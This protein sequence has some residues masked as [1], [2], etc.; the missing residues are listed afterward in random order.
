[1]KDYLAHYGS[2]VD[3]AWPN[4][5]A[6]NASGAGATDGTPYTADFIDDL[7]G[8]RQD[9]L[10]AV[11]MIPDGITE[12]AG[13]SQFLEAFRRGAGLPPGMVVEGFFSPARQALLRLLPLEGQLVPVDTYDQLVD[14]V[15]Q[16]A[17]NNPTVPAFYRCNLDGGRNVAGDF[18]YLPDVRGI[19]LRAAGQSSIYRAANDTPYDGFSAGSFIGDAARK[20]HAYLGWVGN[21]SNIRAPFEQRGSEI[22][23][24]RG[25]D[26][27]FRPALMD[28]SFIGP[29]YP[30]APENRSASISVNKYIAY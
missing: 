3:G 7:W 10:S 12:A 8:A 14:A 17:A 1:M 15:W 25:V 27:G 5:R 19:F 23:L 21:H 2:L 20:I 6:R 18:L 16:G 13:T 26:I 4:T 29:S 9:L 30:T 11:N 28:L 22:G 24:G